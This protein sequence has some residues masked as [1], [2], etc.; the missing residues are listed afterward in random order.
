ML[1]DAHLPFF[2]RELLSEDANFKATGNI[3]FL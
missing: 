3:K 2:T 1:P